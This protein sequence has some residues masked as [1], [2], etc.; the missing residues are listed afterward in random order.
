MSAENKRFWCTACQRYSFLC[1]KC[2]N[3]SC[4]GG[5]GKL[6]D[7]SPC[8]QCESAYQQDMAA[9]QIREWCKCDP[10]RYD[11]DRICLYCDMPEKGSK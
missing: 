11:S 6:L 3:N 8:D 9:P 1:G 7:G 10:A 2:G 4:N 5:S